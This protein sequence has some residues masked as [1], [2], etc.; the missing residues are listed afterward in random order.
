MVVKVSKLSGEAGRRPTPTVIF[1]GTVT[2][3][4]ANGRITRP[5]P[6]SAV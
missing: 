1:D 3:A 2:A 4:G 5:W 6:A